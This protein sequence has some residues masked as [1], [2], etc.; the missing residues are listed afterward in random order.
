MTNPANQSE[1]GWPLSDLLKRTEQHVMARPVSGR[2]FEMTP[3]QGEAFSIYARCRSLFASLR[4]LVEA[5]YPEDGAILGRSLFESS[6]Q[7]EYLATEDVLGREALL[8]RRIMDGLVRAENFYGRQV[9]HVGLGEGLSPTEI[10]GVER[11]KRQLLARQRRLKIARLRRFPSVEA[12]A[13]KLARKEEYL[14]YLY[15]HELTHGSKLALATRWRYPAPNTLQ[16]FTRND[17]VDV[18]MAVGL[19]GA[20]A[21]LRALQALEMMMDWE[22]SG[23]PELLAEVTLLDTET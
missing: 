9:P 13:R 3:I 17:D 10:E 6:L 15:F 19:F 12:I 14:N 2:Y 4:L 20:K 1:P 23:T 16:V 21:V 7:L 22:G 8:I 11:Q 18:L 5:R